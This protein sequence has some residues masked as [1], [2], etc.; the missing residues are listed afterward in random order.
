M[1]ESTTESES[2]STE[3]VLSQLD[4]VCGKVEREGKDVCVGSGDATALY[5]SLRHAPSARLCGKLV[6]ESQVV[7][8]GVDYRAAGILVATACSE[9]EIRKAKLS[10]V[11]PKR[12]FKYGRKPTMATKELNTRTKNVANE[13]GDEIL[14]NDGFEEQEGIE[15]EVDCDSASNDSKFRP[16]REDLSEIEKRRLTSKVIEIGVLVVMRNH[17]Y[18]W[19][20]EVWLQLLGAAIGLRLTGVVARITMDHWQVKVSI[21]MTANLMVTYM[22]TKY[23][24]DSNLLME[25]LGAGA[26]WSKK[27]QKITYRTE[28]ALEDT[29]HGREP[30]EVTM[31]AW[32]MMASDVIPGLKFT[33]DFPQNHEN[34]K[35]PML[36]FMV[37][38][39]PMGMDDSQE[40]GAENEIK[41]DQGAGKNLGV[42]QQQEEKEQRTTRHTIRYEFYEKPVSS[43]LVMMRDSAMPHRMM[44]ASM[45]QEGVRRLANTHRKISDKE[46]CKI[47]G[48]YM[49]KLARSG[50]NQGLRK[51]ILVAAVR[52]QRKREQAHDLG[53]R[54]LHR[55]GSHGREATRRKKISARSEWFRGKG[56]SWKD[57]VDAMARAP[58]ASGQ[59][60]TGDVHK[61]PGLAQGPSKASISKE[62]TMGDR[63]PC[64]EQSQDRKTGQQ[65]RIEAVM[66]LPHTPGGVLAKKLQEKED[67]LVKLHKIGRV[68]MIERGGRRLKDILTVKDPWTSGPCG[69]EGLSCVLW[70][71]PE[72]RR[73]TS[74]HLGRAGERM[75]F[76]H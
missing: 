23:V 62:V 41:D 58:A 51:E 19:R 45:T 3:D 56:P 10:K 63:Q 22:F 60:V 71:Q 46:K 70:T 47:L 39:E 8:E 52:T 42:Q 35:V 38:R 24:D 73:R 36:D 61:G 59:L 55:P 44:M 74:L 54:P 15:V 4:A 1:R 28:D 32:G 53:I 7:I 29:A 48:R 2:K 9:G 49:A 37:W 5:P 21:M 64:K 67:T 75:L 76:T 72:I 65:G 34:R 31:R 12:R 26:R 68:K 6:L 40:T 20:G 17:V 18:Q 69:R 33:V 16:M 11:I 14:D 13:D 30:E 57:E 50:Y 27:L 43:S 25:N 66:F